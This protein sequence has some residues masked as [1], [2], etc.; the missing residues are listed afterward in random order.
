MAAVKYYGD[1]LKF[2]AED[3]QRDREIVM[4]AVKQDRYALELAS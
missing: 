4:A 1:V 3:L 2:A